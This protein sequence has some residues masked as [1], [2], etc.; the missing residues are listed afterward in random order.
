MLFHP[1]EYCCGHNSKIA[2]YDDNRSHYLEFGQDVKHAP[3]A[4][5]SRPAPPAE[6]VPVP[7]YK[8]HLVLE[9]PYGGPTLLS[10]SACAA[11]T[12]MVRTCR[13]EWCWC[14]SSFGAI[15]WLAPYILQIATLA[16]RP[17]ANVD[18]IAGTG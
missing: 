7:G 9:G 10:G 3:P 11:G 13:V 16:A 8:T 18:V 15:S 12:W 5:D 17:E 1:R 2:A 4:E 6:E 14:V